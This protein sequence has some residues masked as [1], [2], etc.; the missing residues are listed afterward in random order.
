MEENEWAIRY[1]RELGSLADLIGSIDVD[2]GPR[3]L[4][5]WQRFEC[6]EE[7]GVGIA[8]GR[9]CTAPV[10]VCVEVLVVAALPRRGASLEECCC[11]C[12]PDPPLPPSHRRGGNQGHRGKDN[13]KECRRSEC[14][15]LSGI[16]TS[17]QHPL[18]TLP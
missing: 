17:L 13:E 15:T 10:K 16:R 11:C 4:V 7:L 3:A 14:N 1:D 18:G 6:C 8:R 9:R 12:S 2:N 5:D